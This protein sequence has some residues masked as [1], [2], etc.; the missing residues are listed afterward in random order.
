MT[1]AHSSAATTPDVDPRAASYPH[2]YP[3]GWYR[4]LDS[5]E[6]RAG[7]ARAVTCLGRDLVLYR[8]RRSGEV[9]ALNAYCPH[10][11]AH[12][13][14]GC[15]AGDDIVC[16]FHHWRIGADGGVK[17][18]TRGTVPRAVTTTSWPVREMHGMIFL[19]Q[20]A[21]GAEHQPMHQLGP[22][23]DLDDGT[24]VPRGWKQ[25]GAARM[26][27]IEFAENSVDFQHFDVLHSG[28]R[29]PWTRIRVPFVRIQH[30]VSWQPDELESWKATFRDTAVLEIFG[31]SRPWSGA[32]ATIEFLGPGG[33]ATFRFELPRLGEILM[34][35]TLTPIAPLQQQV[36]FRWF[37][38]RSMPRLIVW[39][40]VGCWMSQFAEDVAI[41][42]KKIYRAR[43]K[44]VPGDG[45]VQLMRRWYRQFLPADDADASSA[46][47][48]ATRE[49]GIARGG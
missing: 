24:L 11:G 30:S 38:T 13:A 8:G 25:L 33:V 47:G 7:Q 19:F 48:A 34:F 31:R 15:V 5:R 6:L 28:M 40:V 42:E 14:D 16:P 20:H 37:A 18:T 21:P 17:A 12:L 49:A 10:L 35:Q 2:P 39:Y 32:M 22:F 46:S 44:L 23:D 26:H 43:P 9:A 45:P 4:V 3:T 41:W 1:T 27:L 36:R 29:L